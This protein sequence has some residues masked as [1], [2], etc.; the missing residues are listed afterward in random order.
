ML[1]LPRREFHLKFSRPIREFHIFC[2]Y[3]IGYFQPNQI[4]MKFGA[5]NWRISYEI[6]FVIFQVKI[7]HL[8]AVTVFI[9]SCPKC[10]KIRIHEILRGG[11]ARSR[12]GFTRSR[13]G[14]TRSPVLSPSNQR[15]SYVHM[16][17]STSKQ[18][19]F[20]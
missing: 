18:T 4:H 1:L 19:K 8:Q 13:G 5:S 15:I 12:G 16:K 2:S 3:E 17:F 7:W 11:F 14:F 6:G 10:E 9:C 20:I